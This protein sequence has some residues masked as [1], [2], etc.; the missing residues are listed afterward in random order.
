MRRKHVGWKLVVVVLLAFIFGRVWDAIAPFQDFDNP[1]WIRNI[2]VG[3]FVMVCAS[4]V[5]WPRKS[6]EDIK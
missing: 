1:R 3:L 4:I 6:D 5:C 2:T